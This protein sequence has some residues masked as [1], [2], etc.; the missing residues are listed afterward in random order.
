MPSLGWKPKERGPFS[1]FRRPSLLSYARY[2]SLLTSRT[3]KNGPPSPP[4]QQGEQAL[5]NRCLSRPKDAAASP[6]TPILTGEIPTDGWP[7]KPDFRLSG[8]PPASPP[9]CC[10]AAR[11]YRPRF[12][13]GDQSRREA[14]AFLPEATGVPIALARMGRIG[15]APQERSRKH[16]RRVRNANPSAASPLPATC[17][18]LP[19]VFVNLP[20]PAPK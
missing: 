19:A 3:E 14:P 8:A 1:S 10:P 9:K 2:L 7:F 17:Y 15:A 20:P 18:L 11:R 6:S 13:P 16:P 5:I 12:Q 4:F